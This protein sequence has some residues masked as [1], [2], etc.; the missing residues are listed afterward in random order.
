MS[1]EIPGCLCED[2][3]EEMRQLRSSSAQEGGSQVRQPGFPG[4]ASRTANKQLQSMEASRAASSRAWS[5]LGA[6]PRGA[7]LCSHPP[8][9]TGAASWH[10]PGSCQECDSSP[11][12]RMLVHMPAFPP[13]EAAC[14]T[15]HPCARFLWVL[16]CRPWK[17]GAQENPEFSVLS[18]SQG[19]VFFTHFPGS[20]TDQCSNEKCNLRS[21]DLL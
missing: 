16:D 20:A 11:E 3:R 12:G 10:H 1:R 14:H 13:A 19:G 6:K 8:G 15:P 4:A 17:G 18:W 21:P 9:S 5:A 7:A 2:H